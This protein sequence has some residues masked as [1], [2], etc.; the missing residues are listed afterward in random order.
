LTPRAASAAAKAAC[1]KGYVVRAP[2]RKLNGAPKSSSRLRVVETIAK[3]GFFYDVAFAHTMMRGLVV[4][5]L[6]QV[7]VL[8]L[9]KVT[10]ILRGPQYPITRISF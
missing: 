4:A 2:L 6:G 3:R 8:S 1:P 5:S 10:G 9:I 7:T